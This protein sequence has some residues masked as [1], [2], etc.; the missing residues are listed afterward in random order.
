MK[1]GIISDTHSF[2]DDKVLTYLKNV[3]EIW[4]AGDIGSLEVTKTLGREKK[5]RAVYGNIDSAEI[6]THFPKYE[7]FSIGNCK[8]LL[9]HI[10]GSFGKYNSET[11]QLIK[12]HRPNILVCGHSHIVKVANDKSHKLLYINSGAAGIYGFHKVRTI[13]RFEIDNDIPKNMELI[14]LGA[15]SL[16]SERNN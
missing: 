6:R 1:I 9:I 7:I 12:T 5:L 8:I 15:R 13:I 11:Q 14:E 3:D 10:A 2:L 16:I 4:H